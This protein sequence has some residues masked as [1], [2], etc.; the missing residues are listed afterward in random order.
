MTTMTSTITTNPGMAGFI[1]GM[2]YFIFTMIVTLIIDFLFAQKSEREFVITSLIVSQ[3]MGFLN[4]RYEM[5]PFFGVCVVLAIVIGCS[6][7]I[8]YLKSRFECVQSYMR[9]LLW[10]FRNSIDH[11][12]DD[13][14]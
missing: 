4:V 5:Q 3:V 8:Y 2:A 14:D 10:D 1:L 12:L 9:T 13:E 11:L 7:A 6:F